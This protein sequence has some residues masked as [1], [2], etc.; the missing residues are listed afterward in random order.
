MFFEKCG[1]FPER[2]YR[3][4]SPRTGFGSSSHAFGGFFGVAEAGFIRL[5]DR[6]LLPVEP[7]CRLS[8]PPFR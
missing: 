2:K 5:Q 8:G 6:P 3:W 7:I 4:L 1:D